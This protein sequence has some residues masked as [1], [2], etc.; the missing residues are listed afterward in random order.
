VTDWQVIFL[1]IMAGALV[2]M[3]VMQFMM[4]Q[5][6]LRA[7][8]EVAG[9]VREIQRDLG[10]LIDKAT[11]MTDDAARVTALTLAQLERADRLVASLAMR[12][13]ATVG[14]VQ[15]A[16]VQPMKQGA[17]IIAAIR[18]VTAVIREWQERKSAARDDEDPLFVG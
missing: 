11:R 5:A 12:V 6:L 9:A 18:A 1:G 4:A 2:V 16:I 15:D 13:E 17:T 14:I 3:A 7:S 10:P 8:R